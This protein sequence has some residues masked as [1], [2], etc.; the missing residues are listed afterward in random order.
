M[1]SFGKNISSTLFLFI[2]ILMIIT[3]GFAIRTNEENHE[4]SQHLEECHTKVTKRC[5]I[6][7]SNSIYTNN[8][9]SEYC[10]QKHITTGKAC[11]DD[12]IKLFISKVPKEKVTFVAAKGDQ[13]WNHCA[14]IV[15]LA[16]AA[17]TLPILP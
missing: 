1:G 14:V 13:I 16:P 4:L 5:A 10:C 8:T 12:F 3:P 17:S 2:G 7:I 11:H 9:P 6:E 15:A